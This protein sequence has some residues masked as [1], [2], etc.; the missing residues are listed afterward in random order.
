MRFRDRFRRIGSEV[1]PEMLE[2]NA[3][4]SLHERQRGRTVE[5]E[6]PKVLQQKEVRRITNPRDKRIEQSDAT[7]LGGILSGV[8]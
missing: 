3:L 4:P 8:A 6:M 5:V 7:H 1:V 2:V